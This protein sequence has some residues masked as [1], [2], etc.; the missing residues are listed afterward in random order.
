MYMY[1]YISN[2][3]GSDL[4]FVKLI[5]YIYIIKRNHVCSEPSALY[6]VNR[7]NLSVVTTT[8]LLKEYAYMGG[9]H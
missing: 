4:L 2:F 3:V 1:I 8:M 9:W 6:R 5:L 7:D